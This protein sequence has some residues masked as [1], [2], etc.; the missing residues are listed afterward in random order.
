MPYISKEEVKKIR[1]Q[2]KEVLPEFKL[3]VTNK[4]YSTVH[5]VILKG[6]LA[7][8]DQNIN[9]IYYKKHLEND[10]SFIAVIDKILDAVYGT[11]ESKCEHYDADYGSIP[12]Y[13]VSLSV[14]DFERKYQQI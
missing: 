2:L 1:T 10:P 11:K 6:P 8:E 13:Y 3:S 14:G 12:S 5:V 4:N 9:H 7:L